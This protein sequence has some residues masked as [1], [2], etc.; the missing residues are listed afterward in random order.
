MFFTSPPYYGITHYHK[1]QWLRL[2]LL[3]GENQP[4]WSHGE[5]KGRFN[6]KSEYKELLEKVFGDAA[7]IMDET[8]TIYIRTNSRDFTK[9]TTIEA[10]N[11]FFSL[12][13]KNTLLMHQFKV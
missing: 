6:S 2:W 12:T 11:K 8:G 1:D 5:Y 4:L 13:G 10:L 7:Q 3:G 9:I